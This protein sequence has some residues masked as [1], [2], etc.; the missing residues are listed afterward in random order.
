[1]SAPMT[2]IPNTPTNL[3][4]TNKSTKFYTHDDKGFVQLPRPSASEAKEGETPPNW[5]DPSLFVIPVMATEKWVKRFIQMTHDRKYKYLRYDTFYNTK[6]ATGFRLHIMK[7]SSYEIMSTALFIA[8]SSL[9]PQEIKDNIEKSACKDVIGPDGE[10]YL[11]ITPTSNLRKIA[12]KALKDAIERNDGNNHG[13]ATDADDFIIINLGGVKGKFF[14]RITY[15]SLILPS[16]SHD[17]DN[18]EQFVIGTT[19]AIA[20]GEDT[21]FQIIPNDSTVNNSD[22]KNLGDL[23]SNFRDTTIL[24]TSQDP[25]KIKNVGIVNVIAIMT[26]GKQIHVSLSDI[27]AL[28]YC[29]NGSLGVLDINLSKAIQPTKLATTR[30]KKKELKVCVDA[31]GSMWENKAIRNNTTLGINKEVFDMIETRIA[32]ESEITIGYMAFD[33]NIIPEWSIKKSIVC[34]TGN[35]KQILDDLREEIDNTIKIQG[36]RGST[37][38]TTCFDS[39]NPNPYR[40]LL[41][42]TD[43]CHNG[44]SIGDLLTRIDEY[45]KSAECVYIALLGIGPYADLPLLHKMAQVV[46]DNNHV[47][48]VFSSTFFPGS[49]SVDDEV[50]ITYNAIVDRFTSIM[51]E[52]NSYNILLP[53]GY[54]IIHADMNNHTIDGNKI[55]FKAPGGNIKLIVACPPTDDLKITVN[56]TELSCDIRKQDNPHAMRYHLVT[57]KFYIEANDNDPRVKIVNTWLIKNSLT[58]HLVSSEY[59]WHQ[60]FGGKVAPVATKYEDGIPKLNIPPMIRT[61]IAPNTV[62]APLLKRLKDLNDEIEDDKRENGYYGRPRGI[63]RGPTRG[64]GGITRSANRGPTRGSGTMQ[65]VFKKSETNNQP[66]KTRSHTPI[67]ILYIQDIDNFL[68]C[69]NTYHGEWTWYHIMNTINITTYELLKQSHSVIVQLI[70]I[71]LKFKTIMNFKI[72]ITNVITSLI[73]IFEN[74][75]TTRSDSDI[76]TSHSADI[77]TT[78]S[79]VID[80]I[81]SDVAQLKLSFTQYQDEFKVLS[82][83]EHIK[84]ASPNMYIYDI[85]A[86]QRTNHA[87]LITIIESFDKEIMKCPMKEEIAQLFTSN[88]TMKEEIAQLFTPNIMSD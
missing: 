15:A 83:N 59:K 49:D 68:T 35:I 28:T 10:E 44:S 40:S 45:C 20:P 65:A 17:N 46:H 61:P 39:N 76:F 3:Y 63:G 27:A 19:C 66:I 9:T 43:G 69:N 18:D 34:D 64:V 22:S 47:C 54:N 2:D 13:T 32:N 81:T 71:N 67:D 11:E 58:S 60:N 38:F 62:L 85:F 80:A 57:R 73:S 16:L 8:I 88:T 31:S 30:A 52:Q 75:K 56:D 33:G 42:I 74:L 29:G 82:D 25:C 21:H 77:I 72:H 70:D 79:S 36:A 84:A 6:E 87:E 5:L 86:T 14:F 55:S 1:M 4:T 24:I 12:D 7:D 51:F 41:L 26:R 78:Y 48:E 50:D 37:D 53:E 23:L